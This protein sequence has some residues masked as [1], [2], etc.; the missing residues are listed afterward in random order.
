MHI[1][2][3]KTIGIGIAHH[4]TLVRVEL[5]KRINGNQDNRRQPPDKTD[6][7]SFGA[8]TRL[9]SVLRVIVTEHA[10]RRLV[11]SCPPLH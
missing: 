3:L 4:V 9:S 7:F 8:K 11:Q 10:S 2:M 5:V 6:Q 1:S